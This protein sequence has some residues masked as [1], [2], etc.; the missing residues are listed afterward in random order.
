MYNRSNKWQEN[1]IDSILVNSARTRC[2]KSGI[3][4]DITREDIVI[5]EFCPVLGM[6]LIPKRGAGRTQSAPSLDRKDPTKGYTKDNIQVMSDLANRM[7]QNATP[8]QLIS[9]AHW[10]L[11]TYDS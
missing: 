8:E 2:K 9:F 4:F 5:P 11:K 6:K 3:F 7:K 1:N 10:V